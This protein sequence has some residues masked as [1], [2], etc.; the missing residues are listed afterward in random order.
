MQLFSLKNISIIICCFIFSSC[1]KKQKE[2]SFYFWKTTYKIDSTEQTYLNQLNVKKLYVRF[3]DVDIEYGNPK[4]ISKILIKEKNNKQ[5]IIP[6]VFITNETFKSLD[7]KKIELLANNCIKQI[8]YLHKNISDKKLQ[9]IQFDCDWTA[10]TSS[11]YFYFLEEIKR[12]FPDYQY[13]CTIRLHQIKDKNK[14][15]IPPV[16]K[17]VLMY[18]AT[19]SP[20]EFNDNNSILDNKLAENYCKNIELYPIQLDVALPIYSWAILE[21]QVGEKRL[22][23][24]I[25]NEILQDTSIYKPLK[26][27]FYLVKKDHYL[28]GNYIYQDYTIK[29]EE[30]STMQ[31]QQSSEYLKNKIKNKELNTI[32]FQLDSSNLVHY[33]IDLFKTI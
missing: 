8:E 24:G 9:E 31:L 32:F 17:G 26:P 14:T 23:N 28:Q 20:L 13:S 4:P 10:S 33:S 3:F 18:Y 25:R 11:S 29:V 22:L 6:V 12:Q 19:T 15:G 30:I 1:Q 16:N 5:Q 21:N 27:N 2:N 7:K